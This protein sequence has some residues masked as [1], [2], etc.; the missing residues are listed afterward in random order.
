MTLK[1]N[2]SSGGSVSIDA[3]ANT[4]PSGSDVTLTL[5]VNDGDA[6][7]VLA[8]N[9]S[10]ALS[11]A[12]AG[13][14]TEADNWRITA[15]WTGIPQNPLS[16]NWER[17]DNAPALTKLGTGLTESSGVFTFP[18][19]G[20]WNITANMMYR[21]NY[22]VPKI[23]LIIE[24]TVDNGSNWTNLFWGMGSTSHSDSAYHWGNMPVQGIIDCTD[25]SNIKFRLKTG[26]AD[27]EADVSGIDF[28]GDTNESLN[29]LQVWKMAET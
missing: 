21:H 14:I 9:G 25:T 23:Y 5:P 8:T 26:G 2:G 10:G 7:Q 6:D 20:I 13:G 28:Y 29:Y 1:L 4:N 17:S 15:D 24:G 19:T 18:S 11:W 16:S 22:D 12:T 27:V 3:P